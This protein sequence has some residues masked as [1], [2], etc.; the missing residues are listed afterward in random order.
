MANQAEWARDEVY[1]RVADF[2]DENKSEEQ[3]L[4]LL[5]QLTQWVIFGGDGELLYVY[6]L[7]CEKRLG[8]LSPGAKKEAGK[9]LLKCARVYK[10]HPE[11]LPLLEFARSLYK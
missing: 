9:Q 5:K 8:Q 2:L 6:R 7:A 10:D 4:T 11:A 1:M 3:T